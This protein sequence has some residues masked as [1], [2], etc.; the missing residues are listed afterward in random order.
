MVCTF[1]C[2]KS[3]FKKK[4]PYVPGDEGSCLTCLLSF[5]QYV[6]ECLAHSRCLTDFNESMINKK[7]QNTGFQYNAVHTGVAHVQKGW[8]FERMKVSKDHKDQGSSVENGDV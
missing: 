5:N 8:V 4:A 1:Q 2:L 6:E 3:C 7:T